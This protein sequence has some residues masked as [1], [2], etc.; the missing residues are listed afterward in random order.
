MSCRSAHGQIERIFELERSYGTFSPARTSRVL[1]QRVQTAVDLA[2]LTRR[3]RIPAFNNAVGISAYKQIV[4]RVELTTVVLVCRFRFE[5]RL[6]ATLLQIESKY[7]I[8]LGDH[9]C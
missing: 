8:T 9:D 1:E 6:K 3:T 4:K 7:L 5:R 2:N